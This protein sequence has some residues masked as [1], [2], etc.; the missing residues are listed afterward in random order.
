MQ[1]F[2]IFILGDALTKENWQKLYTAMCSVVG[3]LGKFKIYFVCKDNVLRYYIECKEN[4]SLISNSVDGIV[5]RPVS[6]QLDLPTGKHAPERFVSFVTGGSLIDLRERYSIKKSRD[7][8]VAQLEVR[9]ISPEKAATTIR[10]YFKNAINNWS[11]SKKFIPN[12]PV[13]LLAVDFKVAS[14]YIKHSIPKYLNIEKSVHMLQSTDLDALFEVETFPYLPKNY[15]LNLGGY[16]F[17]KHSII[18]GGS[19]TGKSKLIELI[20][21]RLSLQAQKMNYRVVVID[22][23]ANIAQDLATV[24]SSKVIA[25]GKNDGA[26]LFQSANTD[27][28]SA[29]EL[30]TTLFQSILGDQFNARMDRLLRF[31]LYILLTAQ[32]MTLENLKR[33]MTDIE[34]RNSV[35]KHVESFVPNNVVKFFGADYNEIRTQHYNQTI[36]PIVS[37]IDEMQLQ[38]SLVGES[39]TSLAKTISENFLTVFSLNK[40][41]MGEKVVKTVAGL[42]IQQ[43]FLL[44][45]ARAF[46]ERIIL[47]IDEVSVVQNPTL[48]QILSE[49]RKFNLSVILTQ[50]YFGQIEKDLRDAVF[51]NTYNYYVFKVSEED[52]NLLEGNL[53]IELPQNSDLDGARAKDYRVKLMTELSPRECLLRLL[54]NGQIATCIKGRTLDIGSEKKPIAIDPIDL[55]EIKD[56]NRP[57]KFVEGSEQVE[58][59]RQVGFSKEFMDLMSRS[60]K[61]TTFVAESP[62]KQPYNGLKDLL[63]NHSSSRRKVNKKDK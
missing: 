32:V 6:E 46:N 4:I 45:Q 20:V 11:V 33:F 26:D 59:E 36:M 19:G 5:L 21:N 43:I 57:E 18:L 13:N 51:A 55:V 31:S 10:L 41:S 53:N 39:E 17:D 60:D 58:K 23:H 7:L 16:E 48:S 56:I 2:E 8:Q 14:N 44:A 35:L 34:Y 28:S 42:L 12:F 61:S 27:I 24:E 29:T 37:M 3:S 54:S 25:F 50:Q 22:P 30:T 63:T 40:V 47:F 9:C 1:L 49:A 15:F 62:K 38:P 52:A